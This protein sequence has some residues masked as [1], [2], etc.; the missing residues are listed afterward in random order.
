[1]DVF[2][3]PT[4]SGSTVKRQNRWAC[5]RL[6]APQAKSPTINSSGTSTRVQH[7]HSLPDVFVSAPAN[8]GAV[9]FIYLSGKLVSAAR[10][11]WHQNPVFVNGF[12]LWGT[13]FGFWQVDAESTAEGMS[14]MSWGTCVTE[15]CVILP[16]LYQP[17]GSGEQSSLQDKQKK[18]N[19][20][21][22]ICCRNAEHLS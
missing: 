8:T 16:V 5:N 7:L 21:G 13:L 14:R 1:M 17:R 18:K 19:P 22:A 4:T 10:Q 12:V 6:K 20:K 3:A 11:V 15:R 9:V 2:R